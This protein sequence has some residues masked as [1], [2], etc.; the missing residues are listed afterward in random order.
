MLN[1]IR[2]SRNILGMNARNLSYI[3]PHNYKRAI[4]IADDKLLTKKILKNY[5]RVP[6]LIGKIASL[7][8]LDTFNWSKLPDSF[9][10][11]PN[12][13]YG[14]EGI[15]IV[16]G[17]KKNKENTW[18]RADKTLVTIED[19]KSHIIDILDGDYSLSNIP[20][21]AFFEERVLL[22]SNFKPYTYRGI[23]DI[24]VIVFNKVPVMAMLRIPTH[25]TKGK[26]NLHLGGIGVGIDIATGTTTTAIMHNTV[27]DHL[28]GKKVVLSGI[29]IP[30]WKDIL[31]SAVK[32]QTV[33][34]VGFLGA[35]VAIDAEKGPVFLELNARPGLSIQLANMD[36]L[37]ARLKRVEG[38]VVPTIEKGIKIGMNL[39]GGEIEEE[40]EEISGKKVIGSIEKVTIKGKNDSE[41]TVEAKID[42]GADSSSIDKK[43]ACELGYKHVIRYFNSIILPKKFSRKDIKEIELKLNSEHII[44]CIDLHRIDAI[45]AANG[46]LFRPVI[47]LKLI[48]DG[49]EIPAKVSISDRKEL[50]YNTIIGKK[51]LGRFLID[52]RR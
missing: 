43:L 17:R 42:T 37:L 19:L 8:D 2:Y 31:F 20:D 12:Y 35:D 13:G 23:P 44:K 14:G 32:A 48:I 34:R 50:K 5:V 10:L 49:V 26:A 28:P 51:D 24:R 36:G 9:V 7:A 1:Y 25:S 38:L 6:K 47:A 30:F 3:R 40:I 11:K 16:Q 27:I 4:R 46:V 45:Y 33:S 39:F 52:I 15:L 18:V 29:K 22:H 21:I 41:A